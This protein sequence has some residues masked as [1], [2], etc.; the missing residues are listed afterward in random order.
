MSLYKWGKTWGKKTFPALYEE[1]RQARNPREKEAVRRF[2]AAGAKVDGAKRKE[3]YGR[4]LQAHIRI[5]S[6]HRLDEVL[7]VADAVLEFDGDGVVV[8]AGCFKGG[9]AAK[10]SVAAAAR[11]RKLVLFDS[12][13]GIPPNNE[14]HSK[15]ITGGVAKFDAG[16]YAGSL[17]E[18]RGNVERYGEIGVCEFHKGWFDNTMP[19]FDRP[20]AVAYIDVDLVSSTRTCLKYLYPRLVPGGRIFSQ[21]GHL[22]LVIELLED[23]DF[24]KSELGV[25]KPVIPGLGKTKLVEIRKP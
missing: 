11:G 17:E 5:E 13:E 19:G 21:D 2:L 8:E 10:L 1:L 9:R 14:A 7:R 25:D 22:P 16:D 3:L 24:W 6:A 20:V 18:V 15:N 23:A 12:F 4:L